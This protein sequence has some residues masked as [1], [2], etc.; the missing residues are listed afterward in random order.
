MA[1]EDMAIM[2]KWGRDIKEQ[3]RIGMALTDDPR[4]LKIR[5]FC[6]RLN[7]VAPLVMI[8]GVDKDDEG[9]P[10]I[11]IHKQIKFKGV[12]QGRELLPFLNAVDGREIDTAQKDAP[13]ADLFEKIQ[14]PVLLKIYVSSRCPYCP[15]AVSS[16][17]VLARH[18]EK[19]HVEVIDAEMFDD[20]AR[21]D[22]VRSVPTVILDD[23]FRWTGSLNV[24][25]IVDMMAN[26]DPA[27]ASARSLRNIIEAGNAAK[28]AQMMDQSQKVYPGYIELLLHPKWPVRLGAMAVFEYLVEINPDI[29]EEVRL[30]L[31]ERF[32]SVE[33][34][35]KGDAVY[36]MGGSS[37][38]IIRSYLIS[39]ING[40]YSEE[41]RESARESLDG[42][43]VSG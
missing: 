7:V 40:D 27:T 23:R 22:H 37:H 13:D 39:V 18:S 3:V 10:F 38:P 19:I 41:V 16:L 9:L 2:E 15:Q 14:L 29:A 6:T 43:N 35:V 26:Q 42:F 24:F 30:Q 33:D 32:E 25:D 12:P 5:E 11:Q 17:S 4:S 1:P 36:L 21:Q 31:W 34:S 8:E 20:L 28:L